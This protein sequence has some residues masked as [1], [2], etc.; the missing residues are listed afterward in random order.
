MI[1]EQAWLAAWNSQD[2]GSIIE[3]AD[4][5]VEVHAVTL[6]IEGRHYIGHDG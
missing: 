6:G 5:E 2:A 1:D 4:P 3:I